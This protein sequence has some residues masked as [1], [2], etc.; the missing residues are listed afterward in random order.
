MS[1]IHEETFDLKLGRVRELRRWLMDNEHRLRSTCPHGVAYLGT[2]SVVETTEPSAGDIRVGWGMDD[3]HA[4][5]SFIAAMREPGAF[6]RLVSELY[7]FADE[8]PD[9]MSTT[10]LKPVSA[11]A[12]LGECAGDVP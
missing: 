9:R 8:R 5:D 11:A 4:M 6:H 10:V 2:Y 12:S 3:L 7:Q 1:F